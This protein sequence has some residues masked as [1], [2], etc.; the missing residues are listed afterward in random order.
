MNQSKTPG[1][2]FDPKAD[3]SISEHFRPHWSQS[4][5]IVYITFR[6]ADSIPQQ[7]LDAIHGCITPL[8]ESMLPFSKRASSGSKSRLTTWSEALSSTRISGS[9][10]GK[11]A[12]R[13]VCQ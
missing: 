4:G 3:L 7:V 6:T 12:P 2:L 8:G 9:T 11:M 1:E 13:R 10:F 5:A